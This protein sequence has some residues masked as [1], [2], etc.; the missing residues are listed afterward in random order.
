MKALMALRPWLGVLTERRGRLLL[1]A[2]L[3]L[4]T[5]LSALGLL[6]LSGWFITATA[7]AALSA[8][9]YLDVFTPGGGIRLFAVSRTAS[10]YLERLYNHDTILRLLADLRGRVFAGLVSLDARTLSR[11]RASQWLNRLTA[12]I[13]TLDNL[14]L[15]LL[16][17]PLVA[18]VSV[19]AFA[20]FAFVFL[21]AAGIVLL[22]ILLP[23]GVFAMAG[24]AWWGWHASHRR[25][26]RQERLRVRAI[27]QV[28][29]LAELTSYRAL[30]AHRELW[31]REEQGLVE[32]Q[33][34][35][36]RRTAAG[37]LVVT[38]GIQL[39][40][41]AVLLLGLTALREGQ[42]SGPV[43]V[44]L[45][46]GTLAVSEGLGNLPMAFTQL[47]ATVRAAERLNAQAELKT[48]LSGTPVEDEP[49]SSSGAAPS[50]VYRDVSVVH[51]ERAVFSGLD[52]AIDPGQRIGIIGASGIGK[53]TLAQLAVRAFDPQ[54][55]CVE[56]NHQAI[57]GLA[58]DS[59]RARIGYLTQRSELFHDTLAVNL[60]M[61]D[62]DAS[63][64][65]LWDV[66][67][68]VEL[69]EWAETLPEGLATWVGEQ[70][71]Q[72]SGGQA[73]RVA[74][75][76]V[77]LRNSPLVILDEPLSGLDAD[78][79]AAVKETLDVWLAGRTV[80]LLGHDRQALPACDHC[81]RLMPGEQGSELV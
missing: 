63:D 78:T 77:M 27:E 55:G 74:L 39:A 4:A 81:W 50:L 65:E 66:L 67:E 20:L 49:S 72:L 42:V 7:V 23:L 80:L 71:R 60:R 16:A 32:D 76:R 38:L 58:P 64:A 40:T 14:Y 43:M 53:S 73:R 25:V 18:L 47:G 68:R 57:A 70:G 11:V 33:R 48:P 37:N 2:L 34:R 30:A 79:A 13:D 61:G 17:P 21:P 29:G 75:A 31:A 52:L 1:G 62:P 56:F 26:E 35:L 12:D 45:A 44:M 46:L 15:R 41:L 6:S 36:G 8:S 10:R 69:K 3:M 5:L 22:A 24:C 54:G 9:G 59:L 19:V 28:E 51:G